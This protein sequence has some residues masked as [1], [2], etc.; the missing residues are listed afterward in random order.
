MRDFII[1]V[2]LA[3][4]GKS[5]LANKL[6]EKYAN[7]YSESDDFGR[8]NVVDIIS[9]DAIR[10][11]LLGDENDQSKNDLVFKEVHKRVR[12]SLKEHHHVII[13]ATNINVK[14][15][16]SILECLSCLTNEERRQ[17]RVVAYVVSTPIALCYK[18]NAS[19]DRKVPEFVIEKQLKK[20]EIPFYEEGFDNIFI[21]GWE[22]YYN[23]EHLLD[24]S[25]APEATLNSI[26]TIIKAMDGVSQK[27][28]HH[29]YDLGTHC[30]KS[31][32]EVEKRTN[33]PVLYRAALIHDIGKLYT[34]EPKEDGSGDYRYYSHHNVG[35]YYL[36][37][38][39]DLFAFNDWKD[40]MDV[41]FYVNFHMAP[42]FMESDKSKEKWKK[43]FGKEKF[44]NLFLFNK[45]DKIASG[46]EE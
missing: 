21:E 39:L 8:S 28:S 20:F 22:K 25:L 38:N 5:T 33:N 31:A 37:S 6:K 36:L 10:G 35:T 23:K 18:Q 11:E 32:E 2:G 13:D 3:G 7:I 30:R 14:S 46:R 15:R 1:M 12:K 27:N 19:R 42:F 44:D 4:S 43:I 29:K 9:S 16:K 41:L 24:K 34:G 40:T 17:Y 26:E 45:C